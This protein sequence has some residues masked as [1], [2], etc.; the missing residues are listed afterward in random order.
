MSD[1]SNGSGS[2]TQAKVRVLLVLSSL[3]ANQLKAQASAG[4]S[5]DIMTEVLG[6]SSIV[7]TG[8][9]SVSAGVLPA[10]AEFQVWWGGMTIQGGQFEYTVKCWNSTQ[11][12]RRGT[13][14]KDGSQLRWVPLM[15]D[16]RGV[17]SRPDSYG[18]PGGVRTDGPGFSLCAVPLESFGP[19]LQDERGDGKSERRSGVYRTGVGGGGCNEGRC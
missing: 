7:V 3:S 13:S 11:W 10:S 15:L 5:S 12:G 17:N 1:P 4:W 9:P 19:V 6:E 14:R 18:V 8:S 16:K 2:Q